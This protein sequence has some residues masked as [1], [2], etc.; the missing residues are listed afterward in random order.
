MQKGGFLLTDFAK[1]ER[2]K[3]SA[4]DWNTYIHQYLFD[5]CTFEHISDG[6]TGFVYRAVLK[7]GVPTLFRLPQFMD[8]GCTKIT[9]PACYKDIR[10]FVVKIAFLA[11]NPTG[12]KYARPTY[13]DYIQTFRS[14]TIEIL[15]KDI[16]KESDFIDE[17]RIQDE[18]YNSKVRNNSIVPATISE[19]P[20]LLPITGDANALLTKIDSEILPFYFKKA[21]G[22][23]RGVN[24]AT[25]IGF[26][27]MEVAKDYQTIEVVKHLATHYDEN[28][29]NHA[30]IALFMLARDHGYLHNDTHGGNIMVSTTAGGMFADSTIAV[31][32]IDF[33]RAENIKGKAELTAIFIKPSLL[34]GIIE[35]HK[36]NV[37]SKL[38]DWVVTEGANKLGTPAG[39]TFWKD[40]ILPH[41]EAV[42]KSYNDQN[43]QFNKLLKD[44]FPSYDETETLRAFNL[45]LPG[46]LPGVTEEKEEE[47]EKEK[48][49][50]PVEPITEAELSAMI[51][52]GSGGS[53]DA[54]IIGAFPAIQAKLTIA[55]AAWGREHR[56]PK[57]KFTK[58]YI[59]SDIHADVR[60]FVQLLMKEGLVTVPPRFDPYTD[61]IY[62][63]TKITWNPVKTNTLLVIV[64]DLIDGSRGGGQNVADPRGTFELLL[65]VLLYNLRVSAKAVDSDVLFTIGNH[66]YHMILLD[67]DIIPRNTH[68]HVN[69]RLFFTKKENRSPILFPFYKLSPYF[70]LEIGDAEIACVHASL[71]SNEDVS[72]LPDLLKIQAEILS[73]GLIKDKEYNNAVIE[74][75][76]KENPDGYLWNRDYSKRGFSINREGGHCK[77]IKEMQVKLVVVGHCPTPGRNSGSIRTIMK[78]SIKKGLFMNTEIWKT[79]I[80]YNGCSTEFGDEKKGCVVADCFDAVAAP[81]LVFVDIGMSQAFHDW[82]GRHREEGKPPASAKDRK[83]E[84]L[85]LEHTKE[86]GERYYD[87]VSRK[88][89]GGSATLLWE[90]KGGEAKKPESPV[91][92]VAVKPIISKIVFP[93]KPAINNYAINETEETAKLLW[94]DDARSYDYASGNMTE[95]GQPKFPFYMFIVDDTLRVR[96][97][98]IA[99]FVKQ[100]VFSPYEDNRDTKLAEVAVA[101][102]ANTSLTPENKTALLAKME[103]IKKAPIHDPPVQFSND[104]VLTDSHDWTQ[105]DVWVQ[106]VIKDDP[107]IL[108]QEKEDVNPSG[109][110]KMSIGGQEYQPM[111]SSANESNCP[112]HSLLTALSPTFRKLLQKDKD[113]VAQKFR[114]RI[115]Y[116]VIVPL[117]LTDIAGARFRTS[118]PNVYFDTEDVGAFARH[119]NISILMKEPGDIY[120]NVGIEANPSGPVAA[121]PAIGIVMLNPGDGHFESARRVVNETYTFS[122]DEI[123]A[124]VTSATGAR[125][126]ENTCRFEGD[127]TIVDSDGKSWVVVYRVFGGNECTSIF[128]TEAANAAEG[129]AIRAKS[130]PEA[131]FRAQPTT[132]IEVTK[133]GYGKYKK[134]N[135]LSDVWSLF[136]KAKKP[137]PKP[138]PGPEPKPEPKPVPPVPETKPGPS[139]FARLFASNEKTPGPE[140]CPTE[141]QKQLLA[142]ASLLLTAITLSYDPA[143]VYDR[144]AAE[145][146]EVAEAVTA[147]EEKVK[148]APAAAEEAKRKAEVDYAAATAEEAAAIAKVKALDARLPKVPDGPI[149]RKAIDSIISG[150]TDKIKDP[151]PYSSVGASITNG[152]AALEKEISK[153]DDT[154]KRGEYTKFVADINALTK[155]VDADLKELKEAADKKEKAKRNNSDVDKAIADAEKALEAEKAKQAALDAALA[156]AQAEAAGKIAADKKKADDADK[157][158]AAAA[159]AAKAKQESDAAEADAKAKEDAAIAAKNAAEAAAKDTGNAA[160]AEEAATAAAKAD[161][162]AKQAR[163]A[164]DDAATK[165]KAADEAAET[166]RKAAEDEEEKAAREQEAARKAAEEEAARKAAA[167]EEAARKEAAEEAARKAA[168]EAARKEAEEEAAR[169]AVAEEAAKKAAAEEAKKAAAA[170]AD[171]A[172]KA[173]DEARRTANAAR[174]AAKKAKQ[175]ADD[176]ANLNPSSEDAKNKKTAAKKAE[177]A[178][179][180]A[181]AAADTLEGD[182]KDKEKLAK[183]GSVWPFPSIKLPAWPG[184]KSAI[185]GS[186]PL[187]IFVIH[188]EGGTTKLYLN[189]SGSGSSLS[190]NKPPINYPITDEQVAVALNNIDT[191]LKDHQ[192]LTAESIYVKTTGLDTTTM[193]EFDLADA[194][195]W[196]DRVSTPKEQ[197]MIRL[198]LI[199]LGI[200]I[201]YPRPAWAEDINKLDVCEAFKV[202]MAAAIKLSNEH[203]AIFD[204]AGIEAYEKLVAELDTAK[205]AVI[206]N[207]GADKSTMNKLQRKLDSKYGEKEVTVLTENGGIPHTLPVP[208][209]FAASAYREKITS[210]ANPADYNDEIKELDPNDN[211]TKNLRLRETLIPKELIADKKL[212]IAILESLWYCGRNPTL[213]NDPRCFMSQFLGELR[214][215]KETEQ[216]RRAGDSAEVEDAVKGAWTWPTLRRVIHSLKASLPA[217]PP[218]FVFLPEK[219]ALPT[220]I[221]RGVPVAKKRRTLMPLPLG[222]RP[223]VPLIP[224]PLVVEVRS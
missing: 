116:H 109:K 123:R 103:A 125:G 215:L 31:K 104:K 17:A 63:I 2:D 117:R 6:V 220:K 129:K 79:P 177:M 152:I 114:R 181:E 7:D 74:T 68:H 179:K 222:I 83:G 191:S 43:N 138:K 199:K 65:H 162:E 210:F 218:D 171:E 84:F 145:I 91:T 69:S 20:Y 26:I 98:I 143:E 93:S 105:I 25:K 213:D 180:E 51:E 214:A 170:A 155:Q 149:D 168:E 126:D 157:A 61:T 52:R 176:A 67:D 42:Y 66:D 94:I 41:L 166:A 90:Q 121:T 59:T 159:A 223:L 113:T 154:D 202:R 75:E 178:A 57:D 156:A 70:L 161:D 95:S 131:L 62:D 122:P 29:R 86:G 204:D 19:T 50:K 9:D 219:R 39:N 60:K 221:T 197:N 124:M 186:N 64:G 12:H 27:F 150:L 15:N 135:L 165:K 97:G 47:K 188:E 133:A 185:K 36:N 5:N 198:L 56:V 28:L 193:K 78:P 14:T 4:R 18:I 115:A 190:T 30:R 23:D 137:D 88:E 224:E 167:A 212:T 10:E 54:I 44:K 73:S 120:T 76:Q 71:H 102:E 148:A 205:A 187:Y 119:Y 34:D 111:F 196:L 184:V 110:A 81:H 45:K 13:S 22:T 211:Y 11:K 112:S 175:D 108:V 209:P 8:A 24:K 46:R 100:I 217:A 164:A 82:D 37:E 48:E 127:E 134:P 118:M 3:D 106:A 144:L 140:L 72:Y 101:I 16:V 195:P 33:G 32:I 189:E 136:A 132:F 142:A 130:D 96:L 1:G 203:R 169:K 128:I 173:A 35:I 216:Q 99:S 182:A 40:N 55:E 206:T 183:P 200:T 153:I 201:T 139:L 77:I 192:S 107:A 146:A 89:M 21:T 58:V 38:Y 207:P 87:K 141:G 49:K 151:N 80:K 172:R 147:A 174:D 163:K 160:A 208:N 85:L 158:N 194:A 92:T 53:S